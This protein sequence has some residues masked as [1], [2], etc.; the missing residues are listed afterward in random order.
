MLSPPPSGSVLQPLTASG[1]LTP[2]LLPSNIVPTQLGRHPP[3]VL[4]LGGGAAA[5]GVPGEPRAANGRGLGPH[6]G[7]HRGGG[8]GEWLQGCGMVHVGS[9]GRHAGWVCEVG[10]YDAVRPRALQTLSCTH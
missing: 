10:P 1:S 9:L 3:P 6:R 8:A 7:G 4:R 5:G 2:C